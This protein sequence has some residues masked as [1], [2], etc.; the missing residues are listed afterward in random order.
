MKDPDFVRLCRFNTQ[1][2]TPEWEALRLGHVTASCVADLMA[3]TKTGESASRAKYKYKLAAERLT[4]QSQDQGFV[5]QA[6]QF[7]RDQEVVAVS[8]FEN[9]R[10]IF[11]DPVGFWHHPTIDWFGVSPDRLL[12]DDMVVEVKVPNSAT[13]IKYVDEGRCPPEYFPQVQAQLSA[14]QRKAAWFL[15][16]DPRL[17]VTCPN[18]LFAVMVERDEEYIAKLEAE[19]VRFLGEV[20]DLITKIEG[21]K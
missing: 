21:G 17:P 8:E 19:I 20:Q 9:T 13:H 1:Q 4:G 16:F 7:G 3:R 11:L 15:S 12:G 2:G 5:S 18:R 10:G 14:T 6:M